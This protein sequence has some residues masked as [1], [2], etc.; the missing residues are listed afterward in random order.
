MAQ[1]SHALVYVWDSFTDC[2]CKH[3]RVLESGGFCFNR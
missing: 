3:A 2:R 1:I